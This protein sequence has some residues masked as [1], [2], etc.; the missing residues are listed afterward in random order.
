VEEEPTVVVG[1]ITR[2]H[3][4]HG[5]VSVQSRSDNPDRWVP[6]AVVFRANRSLTVEAVRPRR[7]G[8]GELLVRF[9]GITDRNSAEALRGEVH[10]PR[11]WLPQLPEG[12]WWPYQIEGC[13]VMSESGRELGRV[14]EIVPTPANDLWVAVDEQGNETLIPA[15]RELLIEVA[16]DARRIVVRDIEGL[17][18]PEP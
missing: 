10:V 7:T 1:V 12:E 14:T 13:R 15:S 5:E 2:A 9:E 16:V 17:T 18:A 4:L 11:S 8:R 3:G 6:G